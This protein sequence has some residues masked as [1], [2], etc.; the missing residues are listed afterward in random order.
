L[1]ARVYVSST[2]V[3]MQQE[4]RAVMDWLVAS[5]HQVVHSYRPNSET[6]RDSCLDDV[7]SSDVYVLIL[8]HRYGWQP[9]DDNPEG[10]SIT[11][12]EFRRAGQSGK[13]RVALLRTS[14]PNVSSSDLADPA[15]LALVSAFRDEVARALRAAEFSDMEGLIQGLSTGIQAELDKRRP[16]GSHSG[17]QVLRLAPPPPVLAGREEL[18]AELDARLTGRESRRPRVVALCGMGG[19][20]K[21]SV[22]LEYAHRHLDQ[23]GVAW[24][25]PAEDPTVLEAGFAELAAQLGLSGAEGWNPVTGVHSELAGYQGEWLL[26]FDNARDKETVRTFLP[27][28]NGQ[29]LITSQDGLWP[30]G[31]AV[32]VPVLSTEVAAA[33]LV[34]QTGERD[35]QAAAA[36]AVE[37]GRLPLA[38]AQA[39]AYLT[40]TGTTLAD[41]LALFQ[42]RRA[43]LLARGE[44]TGHQADVAAT[45]RLGL[46]R[47][48]PAAAGL[49]SLLAHLPPEPVPLL[50]LLLSNAAIAGD[51]GPDVA[52][53]L[54]PLLGDPLAAGD[55][56]AALRRYSLVTLP[57][58]GLVLVHR[59]VQAIALAQEP[60]LAGQWKQ[61]A[62][63][64]VKAAIPA[65]PDLPAARPV[66]PAPPARARA[67]L[68][69]TSGDVTWPDWY[70]RLAS[71]D[72]TAVEESMRDLAR[73]ANPETLAMLGIG[74]G[75]VSIS[76]GF[77]PAAVASLLG[78]QL[79]SRAGG[80]TIE[81]FNPAGSRRQ[82]IRTASEL[83]AGQG[84]SA[85]FAV[86]VA[87]GCVREGVSVYLCVMTADTLPAAHA[88][89]AIPPAAGPTAWPAY[90]SLAVD[91][92]LSDLLGVRDYEVVDPTPGPI[93]VGEALQDYR[94]REHHGMVHMVLVQGVVTDQRPFYQPPER[95]SL[96]I[97]TLLPDLPAQV[98]EFG[99]HED[100]VR[101]LSEASG[102]VVIVG[103]TGAGKSTLALRRAHQAADGRG[104]FLDGSDRAALRASFAAA[105]AQCLGRRLDNVQKE[106]LDS[107]GAFARHR[108]AATARPWVIVV[109]NADEGPG[110]IADLVPRPGPGQLVII[111][112]TNRDWRDYATAAGWEVI[113]IGSLERGDL[114]PAEQALPLPGN[115]L[116]PA[117][118][119]LAVAAA[120]TVS[121]ASDDDAHVPRML[122][123]LFGDPQDLAARLPDDMVAAALIAAAIMPP[124]D[125]R[126]DW[127]ASCVSRPGEMPAAIDR[128]I[129]IGVL[130]ASRRIHDA[131][132]PDRR[133][134][135]LHQ[136]VRAAVLETYVDVT[137][138][139]VVSLICQVLLREPGLVPPPVRSRDDLSW[140]AALLQKAAAC[141]ADPAL[142]QTILPVLDSLEPRGSDDVQ[143]AA[144][145]ARATL[146][147]F[148]GHSD[149]DWHRRAVPMLAIVRGVIRDGKADENAITAA[150]AVCEK[151]TGRLAADQ[152]AEGML[153]RGRTETMRALLLRKRAS[154]L[155]AA[156]DAAAALSLLKEIVEVLVSSFE[157]RSR[158]LG[159]EPPPRP[160]VIS[161]QAAPTPAAT[162]GALSV[163]DPDHHID[164]S[165]FGV[166]GAYIDLA[167]VALPRPPGEHRTAGLTRAWS[168][169]L[170]GYAGSLSWRP[171]D[172]MYRAASLWGVGLVLYLAASNG[173][174]GLDLSNIPRSE[175]IDELWGR[176]DR[177]ILLRV[178]EKCAIRAHEIRAGIAGPFDG[179]TR[180]TRD[181][182]RKIFLAWHEA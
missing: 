87:A 81:P 95:R 122:R 126:Q 110:K 107:L 92:F 116:L 26:I 113:E 4:R 100:K 35:R 49:L 170:W 27:P 85:D 171:E 15:R 90:D 67:V 48:A 130:E 55:A 147:N 111:T 22:A 154:R 131:R 83:L 8:G 79:W 68:D 155:L 148:P 65:E 143:R 66:R 141:S 167:K 156:G 98:R 157:E 169:A 82:V 140:L 117:V 31:Q 6:V 12:L 38:L 164:R 161:H 159:W 132:V 11:H 99:S 121:L 2:I 97:T 158:A 129:D 57:G 172:T 30:P 50:A 101:R 60:S 3:D 21:T 118:L 45:L 127:L 62:A 70:N 25:L 106:N 32:E 108:L 178:A 44:A 165:W 10:L 150:L 109:D 1:M 96:G 94:S 91:E 134:F 137:Q 80:Y 123:A 115:L 56:I 54:G 145:L 28:G 176:P 42:R 89:L 168:G 180:K 142:P 36:L 24:Q 139:T 33:W 112:S 149:A 146:N 103:D 138:P 173:V 69:L 13:P 40:A 5:Q 166:G 102:T 136:L 29:V 119:R 114:D 174:T 151:L 61:A 71:D 78:K 59:L 125:V 64:L 52:P 128:L 53:T 77:S 144:A 74:A 76:R 182:L 162:R 43:D 105:E 86:A 124:E 133:V 23:L 135:W 20:G 9:T 93:S 17:P 19:T 160:Q 58:E 51:L 39:T 46:S 179:D 47:L 75:N 72:E 104:W 153:I 34:D 88:F 14:I 41:Y 175:A 152:S 73:Y 163:P 37:L 16:I 120:S 18:L 181:L 63:A 177:A 7:D 84:S